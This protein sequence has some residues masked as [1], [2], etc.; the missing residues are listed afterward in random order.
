MFP[1][2][3]QWYANLSDEDKNVNCI[4]FKNFSGTLAFM[5]Y[6]LII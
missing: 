2:T 5:T 6:S 3:L 1:A 4:L